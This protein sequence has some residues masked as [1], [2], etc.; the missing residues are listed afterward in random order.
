MT[1]MDEQVAKHIKEVILRIT[2]RPTD[3]Q[4]WPIKP[5]RPQNPHANPMR[6]LAP[7]SFG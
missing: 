3:N 4:E 2:R 5:G 1:H 6:R 7:P